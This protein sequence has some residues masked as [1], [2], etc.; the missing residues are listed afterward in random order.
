MTQ[1]YLYM[2]CFILFKYI[3]FVTLLVEIEKKNEFEDLLLKFEVKKYENVLQKFMNIAICSTLLGWFRQSNNIIQYVQLSTV[4]T[5]K[6][7]KIFG[8]V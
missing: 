6:N 7:G 5:V 4:V 8:K 3:L 1:F 2:S